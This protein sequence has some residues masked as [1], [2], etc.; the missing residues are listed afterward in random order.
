MLQKNAQQNVR[1]REHTNSGW[2]LITANS[3]GMLNGESGMEVTSEQSKLLVGVIIHISHGKKCRWVSHWS[4]SSSYAGGAKVTL[5]LL[6]LHAAAPPPPS[7]E[8]LVPIWWEAESV[9][10]PVWV[11]WN[12]EEYLF[13]QGVESRSVGRWAISVVAETYRPPLSRGRRHGLQKC[14][15]RRRLVVEAY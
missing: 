13:L 6:K 10:G 11:I 1:D 8:P 14:G 9:P 2:V 3:K 4:P 5:C 7:N 15:T 12:R